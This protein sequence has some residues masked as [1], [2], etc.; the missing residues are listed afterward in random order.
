MDIIRKGRDFS[1][2]SIMWQLPWQT[3][4]WSQYLGIEI[5]AVVQSQSLQ[6]CTGVCGRWR[7]WWRSQ[8][9]GGTNCLLQSHTL[10]DE[11]AVNCALQRR[12]QSPGTYVEQKERAGE[13]LPSQG[14]IQTLQYFNNLAHLMHLMFMQWTFRQPFIQNIH[15]PA[16]IITTRYFLRKG[17]LDIS[18]ASL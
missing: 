1:N 14:S 8:R 13:L 15:Q 12:Q 18:V 10:W 17:G 16:D 6:Y 5:T 7:K 9:S 2:L 3:R 11:G 4:M